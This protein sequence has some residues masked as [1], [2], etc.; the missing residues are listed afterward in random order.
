MQT[1]YNIPSV[2]LPPVATVSIRPVEAYRSLVLAAIATFS[3]ASRSSGRRSTCTYCTRFPHVVLYS[4]VSQ[5]AR[6]N[7]YKFPGCRTACYHPSQSSPYALYDP[8]SCS[9]PSSMLHSF[10][11]HIISSSL[12]AQKPVSQTCSHERPMP[13]RP[14]SS[15]VAILTISTS[16]WEGRISRS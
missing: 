8:P 16:V 13:R 3:R 6:S 5:R 4:T 2:I 11:E 7:I 12:A 14:W 15:R 1:P 9:Q 10:L